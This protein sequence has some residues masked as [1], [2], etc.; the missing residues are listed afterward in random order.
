MKDAMKKGN[1]TEIGKLLNESHTS[2]AKLYDVSC[3][4]IESIINFS[5]IC[6]G[7]Y[8]GR[9]MGGGF[10]GCTLN[11]VSKKYLD[12]FIRDVADLFYKKYQ[13]KPEVEVVKFSEGLELI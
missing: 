13:Y 4:E 6:K 12:I 8:G 2:L 5:T 7:F 10:G 3:D 1:L 9:I 11:L